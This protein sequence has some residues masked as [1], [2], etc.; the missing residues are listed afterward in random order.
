MAHDSADVWSRR[1]LFSLRADGR[2]VEQSGVPPDYFSATGQLWGTPV[3]RWWLHRLTGFRWWLARLMRQLE[4]MDLLRLD[5]F[6]A[7]EAYWSVPG[8]DLTAE[9]GPGAPRRG[10]PLLRRLW[11]AAAA[12]GGSSPAGGCP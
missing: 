2:L 3:Y 5:H 9:N 1:R 6:R 12:G 10:A 4:L 11:G 7:L 8:G